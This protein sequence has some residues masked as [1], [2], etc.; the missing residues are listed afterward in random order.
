MDILFEPAVQETFSVIKHSLFN[1][2]LD[3][4]AIS[5]RN[6]LY[7]EMEKHTIIGLFPV[8]LTQCD[9]ELKKERYQI[10]YS[11]M[12]KCAE[13]TRAL[14]LLQSN[15]I[16]SVIIK[17][18]AVAMYYPHPELRMM[19]DIDLLVTPS[20]Y[21]RTIEVLINDGYKKSNL[22]NRDN[23]RRHMELFKN[24]IE[25]EIHCA[26]LDLRLQDSTMFVTYGIN[27]K[28]KKQIGSNVFYTLPENMN[29]LVLLSH[30]RHHLRTGIGLRQIIDWMLYANSRLS[31]TLWEN[32]FAEETEKLGLRDFT[33]V[34]TKMCVMYLGLPRNSVSWCESADSDL[35]TIMMREIMRSGNFG[36][37]D[38][39]LRRRIS[40]G[41]SYKLRVRT[42][43]RVLQNEGMKNK[44]ISNRR[45]LQHFAWLYQG[46][47][48][49][50]TLISEN[51]SERE[52][53]RNQVRERELLFEKLDI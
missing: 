28:Q 52:I 46:F 1:F 7:S 32:S 9:A 48:I 35:C 45:Y 10:I 36:R 2:P 13:Q 53:T 14:N 5:D 26:L 30:I 4:N 42:F 15:G 38:M 6:A 23:Q 25:I 51:R 41:L 16:S 19:G 12:K 21:N 31:K 18:S 44:T 29:G 39:S 27:Q 22:Q 11:N 43:F 17:G 47:L 37:S 24:G 8:E 50:K 34:L 20:D 49:I 33:M 40:K 3:L